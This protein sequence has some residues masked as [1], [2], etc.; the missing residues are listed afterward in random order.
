[1][2]GSI[3]N[4][5]EAVTACT[6][7]AAHRRDHHHGDGEVCDPD[8]IEVVYLGRRAVAVCHDCRRDSGFLPERDAN[9]LAIAHRRESDVDE[10][11][12]FSAWVA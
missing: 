2:F 11:T 9:R 3:H 12:T 6:V 1:M 8:L 7:D 5:T 10:F 4:Q